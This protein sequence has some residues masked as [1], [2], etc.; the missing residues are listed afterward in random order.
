M[1]GMKAGTPNAENP[2][3]PDGFRKSFRT[4]RKI[5]LASF[6]AL[7]ACLLFIAVQGADDSD[8]YASETFTVSNIQYYVVSED[9]NTG[10]VKLKAYTGSATELEV[11]ATV[12]HSEVT[13]TVTE[14]LDSAFESKSSLQTVTLPQGIT[15]IGNYA[16]R[17]CSSLITI[18]LEN[19]EWVGTSSFYG[20]TNLTG[21]DLSNIQY[22]GPNA[23]DGCRNI[24]VFD[25][26]SATSIGS[27]AFRGM[28]GITSATL[29][30]TVTSVGKYM[31]TG[32]TNLTSLQYN[33][34]S[35]SYSD[36]YNI[37]YDEIG[38]AHV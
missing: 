17:N 3:N 28:T 23:F 11:P 31:F 20:C 9:G 24:T 13:Y 4:G 25:I 10:I 19:V 36:V 29:P 6:L 38:R 7:A 2:D 12:V 33:C 22:F 1:S 27:Y 32:C 18:N 14:I 8:A 26:G 15:K 30:S 21:T 16:F 5:L 34:I 37:V 35:A